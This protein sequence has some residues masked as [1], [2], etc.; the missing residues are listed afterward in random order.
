MYFFLLNFI[1]LYCIEMQQFS[2]W[3]CPFKEEE[4]KEIYPEYNQQL[5]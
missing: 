5:L 3:E 4:I 2:K 1:Y